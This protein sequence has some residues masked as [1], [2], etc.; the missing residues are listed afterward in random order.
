M[1]GCNLDLDPSE[2]LK[3]RGIP[4][5]FKFLA[6]EE[7]RQ[8]RLTG[9][10]NDL[11][12]FQYAYSGIDCQL[13]IAGNERRRRTG[14]ENYS[15]TVVTYGEATEAIVSLPVGLW[16]SLAIKRPAKPVRHPCQLKLPDCFC[17]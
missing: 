14:K 9:T 10:M 6:A 5:P 11:R 13:S 16:E 8:Y 7:T 15:C 17:H 3:C 1:V 12:D 2:T 4:G